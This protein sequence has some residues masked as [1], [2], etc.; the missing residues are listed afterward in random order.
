[1]GEELEVILVT[2]C[3]VSIKFHKM[4]K[5]ITKHL[6]EVKSFPGRSDGKDLLAMWEIR[7]WTLGWEVGL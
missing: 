7:V 4:Q 1:M 3:Y 6:Y 2:H 5:S